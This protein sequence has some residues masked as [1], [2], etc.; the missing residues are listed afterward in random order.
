MTKI[1]LIEHIEAEPS[2]G[3]P[4]VAGK[5]ITV[6]FLSTLIDDPAWPMSRICENYE[7]TPAQIHA[8]WS[9]YYDHQEEIDRALREADER[10]EKAAR[11]T[12]DLAR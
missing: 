11:P 5:G 12:S 6:A 9:Y 10:M 7:L 4:R 1:L 2:T 3:K 8:A